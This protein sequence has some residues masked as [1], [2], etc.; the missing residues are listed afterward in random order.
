M[1]AVV[2]TPWPHQPTVMERSNRQTIARM[3]AG[4]M[5]TLRQVGGPEPAELALAGDGLPWR[6]W[7]EFRRGTG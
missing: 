3:G 2:L 1:R 7:L 5:Q 6:E 4:G